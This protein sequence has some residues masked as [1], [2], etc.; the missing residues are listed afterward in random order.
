MDSVHNRSARSKPPC[1]RAR[2]RKR[3][4]RFVDAR[5]HANQQKSC[6]CVCRVLAAHMRH[7]MS[8]TDCIR[9]TQSW[10]VEHIF[11]WHTH[12]HSHQTTYRTYRDFDYTTACSAGDFG[13]GGGLMQ[14]NCSRFTECAVVVVV[15]AEHGY[16]INRAPVQPEPAGASASQV[17]AE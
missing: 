17:T 8:A 15:V 3:L 10:Y 13:E 1:T 6:V 11:R 7:H 16:T 9:N 12:T 14:K 4:R 5:V 2:S